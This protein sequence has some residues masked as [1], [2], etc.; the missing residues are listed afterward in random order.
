MDIILALS[1]GLLAGLLMTRVVKLLGLPAVTG[2]LVA[3]I[4]VGPFC[5]GRLGALL[6]VPGLG[7]SES[8]VDSM[9]LISDAA[10]GFIAFSIGN[11]FRLSELKSVGKQTFI[12]GVFQAVAA[13]VFVDVSL[14]LLSLIPGS[15]LNLPGALTLG[16]IAAATAPA[17][18]LMVVHQYKAHGPVTSV[19]LPVVALDDA[20]G[21]VLF[22]ISFGIARALCEGGVSIA[23]VLLNPLIEIVVSLLLGAL[24]G[25]ALTRLERYFNSGS[26]RLSLAVTLVFLSV[27]LSKIKITLGE[28]AI[29]FSPLLVCMMLGSVFCNTCPLSGDLMEKT[30]KWTAPLFVIFFVLSGASL[31]LDILANLAVIG[32]GLVYILARAAGKY[33]GARWSSIWA[34]SDR[35]VRKYLGITLFPQAGVALGMS[36][37][38][39]QLPGNTGELVRNITLFAVLIYEL[40]GPMLTKMALTKAGEITP[41]AAPIQN[42]EDR[43]SA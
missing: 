10:L 32:I 25:F 17:A 16:A 30:E 21:L 36:L 40:V 31:R 37:M 4:L 23:A 41:K 12:I 20:V 26:N 8:L 24:A 35:N 11:E 33:A 34:G 6:G 2:H 9:S 43:T 7:F 19:L 14:V 42:S 22:A 29:G 13:T 39:T 15:P 1:I 27:A 38:A 3:G 28:F 18:T 5:L